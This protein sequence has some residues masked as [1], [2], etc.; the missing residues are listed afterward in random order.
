MVMRPYRSWDDEAGE[1]VP[2]GVERR[3]D[4]RSNVGIWCY[5]DGHHAVE[6]EVEQRE[7]SEEEVPEELGNSPLEP[8]HRVHYQPVYDVLS[9]CVWEFNY[10]LQV[11]RHAHQRPAIK[12]S[13]T[14]NRKGHM[15]G[16]SFPGKP[17]TCP[18]AYGKA[19]YMPAALSR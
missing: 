18:N 4:D 2:D 13:A 17:F 15:D 11:R 8:D 5:A 12:N 16:V 9:Q 10:H 7:E 14:R 6:C 19:E 1:E 3:G